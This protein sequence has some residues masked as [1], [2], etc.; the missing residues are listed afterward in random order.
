MTF[1]LSQCRAGRHLLEFTYSLASDQPGRPL[2]VQINGGLGGTGPNHIG[3]QGARTEFTLHFPATG[4]WEE[5]G[6]VTH[7]ADL[8]DGT[9]IITVTAMSNSG[10]N[11]VSSS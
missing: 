10:P 1:T 5:W 11:L 6:T 7:R 3:G 9:N 2:R 8:L 4:S